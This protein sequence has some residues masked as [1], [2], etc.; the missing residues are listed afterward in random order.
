MSL[1]IYIYIYIGIDVEMGTRAR[2]MPPS[3]P[4]GSLWPWHRRLLMIG[5]RPFKDHQI[6]ISSGTHSLACRT[7]R[8]AWIGP[9]FCAWKR[10]GLVERDAL[11]G[12]LMIEGKSNRKTRA[13]TR[14]RGTTARPLLPAVVMGSSVGQTN[15]QGGH[16][17]K[18]SASK[19]ALVRCCPDGDRGRAPR[20]TQNTKET[21]R[22]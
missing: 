17:S 19:D 11:P 1:S 2:S 22:S 12:V 16:R 3:Q 4:G 21:A 5:S 9:S 20:K 8:F 14:R 18:I 7:P 6:I 15:E 13:S 10:L